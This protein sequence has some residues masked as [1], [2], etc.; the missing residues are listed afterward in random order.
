MQ[1]YWNECNDEKKKGFHFVSLTSDLCNEKRWKGLQFG[2]LF[3]IKYSLLLMI[4]SMG[5]ITAFYHLLI[6]KF[7]RTQYLD[8]LAVGYSWYHLLLPSH[9]TCFLR[10]SSLC[11]SSKCCFWVDDSIVSINFSSIYQFIWSFC[12]CE[13]SPIWKFDPDIDSH[14]E[15]KFYCT[16]KK[17]NYNCSCWWRIC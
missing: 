14:Q 15:C 7:H 5:L 17:R 8:S 12:S 2:S 1:D 4:G 6:Y 3:Y 9:F 11:N 16:E 13:F 10:C